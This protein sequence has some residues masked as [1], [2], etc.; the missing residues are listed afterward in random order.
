MGFGGGDDKTIT[1]YEDKQYVESNERNNKDV[2]QGLQRP[3][4]SPRPM[5][6]QSLLNADDETPRGNNLL[7]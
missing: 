4:R 7:G 1:K 3:P 2:E 5:E 6:T